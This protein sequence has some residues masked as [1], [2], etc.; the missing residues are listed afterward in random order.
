MSRP[1][2]E[3][4]GALSIDID[5][6][7]NT[8]LSISIEIG[9]VVSELLPPPAGGV[10]GKRACKSAPGSSAQRRYS[11]VT[12][13]QQAFTALWTIIQSLRKLTGIDTDCQ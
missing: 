9:P 3:A 6:L 1:L 10:C 2:S 11:T 4:L 12:A 5:K 13:T 7:S 8:P